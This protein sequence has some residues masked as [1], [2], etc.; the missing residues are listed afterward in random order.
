MYLRAECSLK[1]Q[2]AE[3]FSCISKYLKI[4]P[5]SGVYW[6][7]GNMIIMP[8][9]YQAADQMV[10]ISIPQP[11]HIYTEPYSILENGLKSRVQ[12]NGHM[13]YGN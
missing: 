2:L 11:F 9:E 3:Q 4:I 6:L 5:Y 1:V 10:L 8:S 7:Y 13:Y 12:P